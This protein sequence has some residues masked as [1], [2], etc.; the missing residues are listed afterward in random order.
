MRDDALRDT[1]RGEVASS[2]QLEAFL[3]RLYVDAT[4]RSAFLADRQGT[5][6]AAGLSEAEC[7]SVV[8]LDAGALELAA[9]SFA[10]KRAL[11]QQFHAR[12]RARSWFQRVWTRLSAR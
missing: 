8:A 12:R 7:E 9:R 5:A 3:A 6:I 2:A 4:A 10:Y 1:R 11:A